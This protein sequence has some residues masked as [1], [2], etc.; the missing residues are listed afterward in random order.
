VIG[1]THADAV[2][3]IEGC[4]LAAVCDLD[5]EKAAELGEA[6]GVPHFTRLEPFLKKVDAV[7]VCVPSGLHAQVGIRAARE[8]KHVVCE[9]PMDVS[10]R[11]AENLIKTCRENGV[12]LTVISQHRFAP[13]I[14][15]V[16]AAAQAGL[17]GRIVAGDAYVKW[18]RTQAYYDSSGWRGTWKLDGGGCLMNQ[19]VH[20]VDMIQWILGPVKAVQAR[21]ATC[22]RRVEV[23]DLAVAIVEYESGA[24]GVIQGSTAVYPGFAER[25]EIHGEHGS[26]VIEADRLKA[27]HVDPDAR[28]DSSLY[29]RGV[30]KQPAPNEPLWTA[31][32]GATGAADPSDIWGE[33]HRLQIADF[34]EAIRAGREPFITGEMALEPVRVILAIYR[35]ARQGGRRVEVA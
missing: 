30:S 31:P 11:A 3:A 33:Q 24:L 6:R 22:A 25:L 13:D 27:W 12:Q 20:Y 14:Q 21:T 34:V 17:F 9:K 32:E 8:G 2:Q 29:G 18:Y 7:C 4:E 15:R 26:A 28:L 10:L 5:P 23:E 16:R 1:P 35:S 19:G